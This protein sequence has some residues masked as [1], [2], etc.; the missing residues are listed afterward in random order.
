V[1]VDFH[2]HM[3]SGY[4]SEEPAITYKNLADHHLQVVKR[5]SKSGFLCW[6]IAGIFLAMGILTRILQDKGLVTNASL[7]ILSAGLGGLFVFSLN[8]KKELA[9]NAEATNCVQRGILYCSPLRDWTFLR[10]FLNC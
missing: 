3:V 1:K 7:L 5:L 2:T 6:K 8:A 4:T 10:S 9:L